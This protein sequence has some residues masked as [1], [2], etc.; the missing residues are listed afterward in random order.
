MLGGDLKSRKNSKISPGEWEFN[1]DL[2][3][4]H[5]EKFCFIFL[6]RDGKIVSFNEKTLSLFE[7]EPEELKGKDFSILYPEEERS[8][9]KP[10]MDLNQSLE[11]GIFEGEGWKSG[12]NR[13]IWTR[14]VITPA[15]TEKGKLKG[16]EISAKEKI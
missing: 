6:N 8:K 12:K 11:N 13:A 5:L 15:L 2:L 1:P 3:K 9:G 7:Y 14:M 4:G 16:F 10:G